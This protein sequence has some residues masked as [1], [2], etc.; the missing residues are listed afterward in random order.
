ME[1][2]VR[3]C[4][5]HSSRKG[6]RGDTLLRRKEEAAQD[7]RGSRHKDIWQVEGCRQLLREGGKQCR[8][9]GLSAGFQAGS[10]EK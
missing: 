6:G 1:Q 8:R 2:Q 7:H 3:V 5:T 10:W 9:D 4:G